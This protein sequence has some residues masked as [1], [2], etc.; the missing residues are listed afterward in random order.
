MMLNATS[1]GCRGRAMP[2]SVLREHRSILLSGTAPSGGSALRGIVEAEHTLAT[3]NESGRGL[4]LSMRGF[5]LIEIMVAVSLLAVIIVGLLAMF[6]QVQRAFRA[7]TAQVDV[8][9]GGRASVTY[10]ASDVQGLVPTYF[11]GATNCFV[12][13]APGYTSTRQIIGQSDG[14]YRDNNVLQNFSFIRRVNDEWIGT[15]YAVR[16][17]DSGVGTLY[18]YVTNSFTTNPFEMCANISKTNVAP[19]V[20][21]ESRT[22][23]KTTN[24]FHPVLDGVVHFS[25]TVYDTNGS[26][27]PYYSPSN[28]GPYTVVGD[29]NVPRFKIA[30]DDREGY[31][32]TGSALPSYIDIELAVL[33]PATMEKF[34]YRTETDPAGARNIYLLNKASRMH[35]FRQRIAI[36]PGSVDKG[37]QP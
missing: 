11:D 20:V 27:Y 25:V 14:V 33:E 9:E 30:G 36:R 18:R 37:F 1:Q 16:Y 21:G 34:K 7:G 24:G 23:P 17:A 12:R 31:A 6:Y 3:R 22:S 13:L 10:I 28:R 32:F 15:V 29:N 2:G 8:M 5:S 4:P 19:P 35:V 26:Y